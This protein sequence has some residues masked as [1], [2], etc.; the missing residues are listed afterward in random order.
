MKLKTS[1]S[2][3]ALA[4]C[5]AASTSALAQSSG[6][7]NINGNISPVSCTPQLTGGA[8]S[9]NTLTLPDAFID[10][11]AA[12]GD[13]GG[14]TSFSFQLNGCTTSGGI[15]N[16]WVHFSGANID[17][18]GRVTPTTGTNNIRFELVDLPTG[19]AIVAGG[20][21]GAAPG[22]GQGTSAPFNPGPPATTNRSATKT[23]A[24]RYYAVN[25]LG[26]ADVGA[27]TSSVT[28]NVRYH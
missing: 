20:A 18:N 28:Y 14:Q 13:T 1:L 24:V 7:L 2:L 17:G 15:N 12:T 27:V 10:D 8:I 3:L 19:N 5:A 21:A 16:V 26:I 22:A 11:Y 9:G 6:T 4:V 25:P 23:Y